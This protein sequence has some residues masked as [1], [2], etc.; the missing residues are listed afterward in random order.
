MAGHGWIRRGRGQVALTAKCRLAG[1]TDPPM[2]GGEAQTAFARAAGEDGLV[3]ESRTFDWLGEQG[4]VGLPRALHVVPA[5]RCSRLT[6][7]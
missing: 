2:A 3:L 5:R 1:A 4:H 6:A 7:A